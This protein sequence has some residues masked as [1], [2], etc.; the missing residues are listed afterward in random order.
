MSVGRTPKGPR[1]WLQPER[2]RPGR[3]SEP[4]VWVI[5]DGS[6]KISTGFGASDIGEAE[7][8]LTRY[9]AEKHEPR[10]RTG[11]PADIETADIL[12]LYAQDIVSGHSRPK[13]SLARIK[14]LLGYWADPQEAKKIAVSQERKVGD[15]VGTLADVRTATCQSYVEWVGARR[16]ATMDLELLR[17]A[18][19]HAWAEQ[20][21]DR[22]IPVWLPEAGPARERWLTRSEVAKVVWAAWRARRV[23]DGEPDEWGHLKHVARF[24]VMAHYTGTRKAAILNA[25]FERVPGA[26]Y[27]DLEAGLWHRRGS[28]VRATKKRQPPVPLPAPLLGHMRRWKK[29]GQVYAVEFKGQPV[30]RIDKAYRALV[31]RLGLGDDVVIHTLRHTAITWGMQRGMDLWDASGYFGVSV[32]TLV[33]VYGH[34]HPA[35]LRDAADKMARP[36]PRILP[37]VADRNYGT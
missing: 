1:L 24:V 11:D 23:Q 3:K 26:G 5:R 37:T 28:G 4:S 25:A 6:N 29:N 32:E 18:I 35:H 20:V 16:T 2:S 7:R 33:A 10:R 17:A 13:E 9:L 21:I 34:H 36:K 22:K 19:N 14:R 15:L 27:I 31:K 30:D 12:A 8:Q